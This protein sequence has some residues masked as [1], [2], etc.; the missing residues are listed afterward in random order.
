VPVAGG[1]LEAE[2]AQLAACGAARTV[3]LVGEERSRAADVSA[4]EQEDLCLLAGFQGAERDLVVGL[5]EQPRRG[6]ARWRG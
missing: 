5:F 3:S 6:L 4:L 2:V 1:L